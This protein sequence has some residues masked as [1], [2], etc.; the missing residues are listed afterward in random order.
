MGVW[1]LDRLRVGVEHSRRK[2]AKNEAGCV[3]GLLHGR[4]LV[5][6]AR[7]RLKIVGVEGK[8][9]DH[10]VPADHVER[11]LGKR[12]AR[13]PA[14]ILDEYRRGAF[15]VDDLNLIR[16]VE[17]ALA[18]WSAEAKLAVRIQI[19][20]WDHDAAVGFEDQQVWLRRGIKLDAIR[21]ATRNDDVIERLKGQH[22]EYGV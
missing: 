3:E 7:D 4:R 14:A 2:R 21:R 1:H 10:A 8:R 11:M 6:G 9:V 20:V 13:Q 18:V 19:A 16:G 15:P 12:V 22:A 17:I 5:H